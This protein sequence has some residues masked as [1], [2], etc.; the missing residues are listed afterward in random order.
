MML[1]NSQLKMIKNK[2]LK[3]IICQ[4]Q[5]AIETRHFYEFADVY[6]FCNLS[7]ESKYQI[8]SSNLLKNF[9]NHKAKRKIR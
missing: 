5:Y 4:I 6:K 2:Q 7:F 9:Q 3:N 8:E 1:K